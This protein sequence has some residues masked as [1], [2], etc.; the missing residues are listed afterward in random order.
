MGGGTSKSSN[1]ETYVETPKNNKKQKESSEKSLG[2]HVVNVGESPYQDTANWSKFGE[3]YKLDADVLGQGGFAVVQLGTRK[4]N[5]KKVAVKIV[6]RVG[7]DSVVAELALHKENNVLKDLN[8]PHVVRALDF[9]ENDKQLRFV[10]EYLDGGEL[11]N[12]IVE[13]SYY[14]EKEARDLVYVLLSGIK[15]LHDKNVVHRYGNI[16]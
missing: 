1:N 16:P 12:R 2:K 5:G 3:K 8:H 14:N 6:N 15:Y 4:D 9:F 10:I 7:E 13:K 11:F